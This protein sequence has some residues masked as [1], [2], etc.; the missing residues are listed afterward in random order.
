MHLAS[1]QNA[2]TLHTTSQYFV[3]MLAIIKKHRE[4]MHIYLTHGRDRQS[5]MFTVHKQGNGKKRAGESS[6]LTNS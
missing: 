1:I 5:C 4:A 2:L 6:I 3:F